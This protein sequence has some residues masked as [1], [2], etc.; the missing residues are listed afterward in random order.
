MYLIALCI[1]FVVIIGTFMFTSGMSAF[2]DI[3]TLI[4]LIS[5]FIPMMF[6]SGLFADF[7]R[8]FNIIATKSKEYTM[9]ELKKSL[10]AIQ[11]A[12]KLILASGLLLSIIGVVAVLSQLAD[13][14]KIGPSL[15]VVILS[16]LYTLFTIILLLP[17][18][19]CIKSL[20]FEREKND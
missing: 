9:I 4:V 10:T 8:A 20:L 5:L 6:A 13:P 19:Y 7:I 3:P 1:F 12:I 14:S 15:A 17:I 11:L 2:F 18:E 16:V